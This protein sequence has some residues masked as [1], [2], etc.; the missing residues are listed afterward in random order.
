MRPLQI[1]LEGFSA[2]REK[3][4]V[5]FRDVEFFSIAGSTGS[6]KSSLVDAMIFALYGR[7]PRLGGNAVAPV[8]TAGAD[9]ARVRF[10]FE[11]DGVEYDATRMAQRTSSGG[12]SVKEAR[13]Q[14]DGSVIADGPGEVTS[15]VEQVLRLGFED[16]TRTVVLPQGDFARFLEA[17]KSERQGLLRNLLGLDVYTRVRELARTRAVVAQEQVASA[18]RTLQALDVPDEHAMAE[19]VKRLEALEK[20]AMELPQLEKKLVLA[21]Q[22]HDEVGRQLSELSDAQSRLEAI[23][24][25][26]RL[27]EMEEALS[28]ARSDVVDSE[29]LLANADAAISGIEAAL[30]EMPGAAE[31]KTWSTAELRRDQVQRELDELGIEQFEKSVS[32]AEHSLASA[33]TNHAQARSD[34]NDARSVHS[35]HVLAGTLTT[36]EQCPVCR[37]TVSDL[38]ELG[39]NDELEKARETEERQASAL[40]EAR[41]AAESAKTAFAAVEA[42]RDQLLEQKA[43]LDTDLANAPGGLE[44]V[45]AR[46]SELS[47]ELRRSKEERAKLDEQK[48]RVQRALEDLVEA[49]RKVGR[50][51][52]EAQLSVAGLGPPVPEA[53]DVAVQ[54][55]ELLT[56]RDTRLEEVNEQRKSVEGARDSAARDVAK[57]Q[58][59]LIDRLETVGVAYEGSAAG[60]VATALERTRTLVE[61]YENALEQSK[62]LSTAIEGSKLT[63][64]TASALAAHLKAN[65]FEQWL[66]SG[67][68]SDLVTGANALIGQ[69]SEGGYSLHSDDSGSFSIIDH[70]NADE[71]RRVETLSGGETFLVSLALALSLA[72]TLSAKGGAGLEAIVLDEG[73]GT[74]DDE[75]LDTVASVLEELAGEGLMVGVITHVKELAARAPTR[76]EVSRDPRGARVRVLQ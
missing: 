3:V 21:Q 74:L 2:Y 66:M 34:L 12:A 26:V 50:S 18:E 23:S 51:L 63:A 28:G 7:V 27:E 9:V 1:T 37:Q 42:K 4:E 61:R 56:W 41:T 68:L 36:G 64:A 10:H 62:E 47:D 39:G 52:T 17:T 11:V 75:S 14:R 48:R 16:F 55:K 25:P 45:I 69:L 67:A 8:I 43:S 33:T 5:D 20:V 49:S 54:W 60:A 22:S 15:Q 59:A 13:L 76:F 65:G 40:D 29:E 72:E 57:A 58:K 35:A 30:G 71:M 38:P 24:A 6:G 70:R 32:E 73:F 44:E 19:T 46:Q 53:D 31:L